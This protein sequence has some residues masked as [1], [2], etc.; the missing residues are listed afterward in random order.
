MNNIQAAKEALKPKEK[1]YQITAEFKIKRTIQI[2]TTNESDL[3]RLAELYVQTNYSGITP[4]T[5]QI[6][7]YT[8][9]K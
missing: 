9:I 5:T 3:P 1:K 8:E 7:E 4:N 6:I 2:N